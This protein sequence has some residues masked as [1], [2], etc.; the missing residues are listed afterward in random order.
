MFRRSQVEIPSDLRTRLEAARL[1]L[2]ALFRALDRVYLAAEQIPQRLIRR[3]FELDADYV[4]ALWGL[5]Q[6][7]GKLNLR[8]MLRDTL[9]AL[10]QLPAACSRFRKILPSQVQPTLSELE[11]TIRLNLS[12]T[13]A[14]NMVKG[15]DPQNGYAPTG[16]AAIAGYC[17]GAPLARPVP[18]RI[19]TSPD[20]RSSSP[21][22]NNPKVSYRCPSKLKSLTRTHEAD[23]PDDPRDCAQSAHRILLQGPSIPEMDPRHRTRVGA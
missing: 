20:G 10:E 16:G 7:P 6:P 3:L 23:K 22:A 19:L 9:A 13:E 21:T 17:N 15:R 4:E 5:D 2:L 12:P 8:A 14:C 1:D 11:F 18:L